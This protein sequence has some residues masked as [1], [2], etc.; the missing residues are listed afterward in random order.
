MDI[1]TVTQFSMLHNIT[2]NTH[3]YILISY[4]ATN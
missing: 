3:T 4:A 2:D 1:T